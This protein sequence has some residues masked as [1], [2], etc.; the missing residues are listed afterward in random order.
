M[1]HV[2]LRTAIPRRHDTPA[3][4]DLL[5]TVGTVFKVKGMFFFLLQSEIGDLYKATLVIDPNDP[6]VVQNLII[7]VFDSIQPANSLCITKS[8]FLFVASEFGNHSFFQF[9]EDDPNAVRS[10]SILDE[11]INEELGDD[12]V[13]ASRVAP[14]FRASGKLQHLN[15]IDEMSSLGPI[16][17]VLVEEM[18]G[19]DAPQIH[20]LCGRGNRS[21]LRIL[22]HGISVTEMAVSELPGRPKAVWTVK[23]SQDSDFDKYIIVSFANATLVLSIGDTVEEVTDSGF[24]SSASTLD[25]ALLADNALLQVHSNGITH[26]RP[27]KRQSL[28]KPPG[29]KLI[30]KATANSRQVVISVAGGEIFYFELDA[31]GQLMELMSIDMELEVNCLDIGEVPEGRVGSP[32][33]AVGCWDN[34]VRLLSLEHSDLLKQRSIVTLKDRPESVCIAQMVREMRST[35]SAV[36]EVDSTL[37]LSI[38]LCNGILHRVAVD[39]V[40]GSLSDSRLR[41]L[42]SKPVKLFR[43]MVQ[44]QRGVLAL[45]S[46]AWLMYNYQGRQVQAPISYETLEF[47]SNFASELCPEGIVAVAG[48]TLRILT[49]DNL[50]TMFNQTSWPLRYTPRKM[51]R[52]P[53]TR[54]LVIVETDH[55]EF[56]EAEKALM[57]SEGDM[58]VDDNEGKD[59]EATVLPLRGPLPPSEG[60]WASC[61][62]VIEPASG[63]TVALLELSEN[64]AAFSVC[65]C[66]F[67]VR[68]EE[69]FIIV[70][71][72]RDLHLHPR[73][74]KASFIHVYRLVEN[75]LQLLHKTEVEDV[76]LSMCEFQGKLLVGI[77]KSLR[78][79]ELGKKK[80]LRKCENKLFPSMI[81][82][83]TCLG[84]RIYVGDMAESVHFAKYKRL[85]NALVIYADDTL[86]RFT[87]AIACIDYDSVAGAD[88]F[89]N[90]FALRLP[91]NTNDDVENPSGVRLLWDQGLLNGAPTKAELICHYHLGEAITSMQKCSLF[92][93][94]EETLIAVTVTGGIFAFVPFSSKEDINFYQHLEMF[95]RQE[96][97]NLC[98]RDHLS[99]RSYFHPVKDVIDGDLCE[100]FSALPPAKQQELS[101]D[102]DRT[103]TEIMKKLEDT[104]SILL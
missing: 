19:D 11:A 67:I 41:L 91:D 37:Y 32:F 59:D 57:A 48:N 53:G 17:D 22:R 51:C 95:L 54:L 27:D 89:G 46:R 76:P 88:K 63:T 9:M 29:K 55:N 3:D 6:K 47:A 58:A 98:Q 10:E 87:T 28:W 68:E 38:G 23:G 49:V 26:I 97:P 1:G 73:R 36:A 101:S 83:L 25:V 42:G 13:S 84:D 86:P 35:T 102:I 12:A 7:T 40:A 16:T 8:G 33:L 100:R 70:G 44:G 65:S 62:R 61:I 21:T 90:F 80:L 39:P 81:V 52:M 45:S 2:E 5:I 30:L 14:I 71:T 92:P 15:A 64:E 31:A 20:T 99:Y 104:R 24:C 72:T 103:P 18:S 43:V 74:S 79:Y 82:K 93:L 50:G 78:L 56:N 60:K 66:K 96:T 85:E 69:T 94:K 34:T 75:T 77:G 4:K